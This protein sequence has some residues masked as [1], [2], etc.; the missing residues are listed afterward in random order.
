MTTRVV[1]VLLPILYIIT[2]Q[3]NNTA[4]DINLQI[5]QL[6]WKLNIESRKAKVSSAENRRQGCY[7]GSYRHKT[8]K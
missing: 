4:V 5:F 7:S 8:G 3:A 6:K 2:K 1:V